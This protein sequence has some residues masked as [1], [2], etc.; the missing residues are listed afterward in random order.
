MMQELLLRYPR[1]RGVV[2]PDPSG[3]ARKT[4]AAVG[5]TDHAIIQQAGWYVYSLK[6]Y[7]VV[8]RINSVNAMFENAHRQRRLFIDR[9]CKKLIRAL[10]SLSFKAET[11]IPD[12]SSGFDHISD[13]LGYLVMGAFPMLKNEVTITQVFI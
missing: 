9:G 11:H 12:K 4:S 10:D 13:A 5:L 7:P 8:D 2:H 1:H 3:A 6:P